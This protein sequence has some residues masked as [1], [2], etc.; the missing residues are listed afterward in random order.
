[1]HNLVSDVIARIL[2]TRTASC[3]SQNVLK[4]AHFSLHAPC[5]Q[6]ACS[7]HCC[8]PR[9][10]GAAPNLN[11]GTPTVTHLPLLLALQDA[12]PAVVPADTA[13]MLVS[14]ALVLLMTPGARVLLRRSGPVQEL[15]QYHDDELRRARR[16]RHRVGAPRPT[17]SPS[18]EGNALDRRRPPTPAGR[19]RRRRPRAPFRTSLF[20]AYQG[21]FAIIT[22]ALISGAIVERMRF[23]PYLAFIALWTLF[24]YAPVAHWVWGGGWLMSR[25]VLDFA[26][27][28]VVHINAGVSALVAALVAGRAQGLRPAGRS[29]RTT[30]RSCCSAPGCSGSAGSASTA[31]ARS[32]PTSSP[33]VAFTNTFLA[34]DGHAGR[35]GAARL[36]PHR[37]RHGGRRRDGD[38]DRPRRHHA[39]RRLHQPDERAAARRPRRVPELLRHRR[40]LAHAARRLARRLRRPRHRR[41]HRRAAHRRVRL[42]GVE[43]GGQ[44]RPAGRQPRRSSPP[45]RSASSRS[46]VYA[47]VGTFVILKLHGSGHRARAPCRAPRDWA[48]TL[49]STAKRPTPTARARSWS[50]PMRSP[51]TRPPAPSPRNRRPADGRRTSAMKLIVAIIRPDRLNEVLEA[52]YRAEVTRSHRLP[53]PRSRRRD[54]PGRDLPR[55]DREDGAAG[56][57]AARDRRVG[58]VR[59]RHRQ[60]DP[61]LGPHRRGGR[62]QGLRA[63]RRQVHRIRTGERDEQAVTPTAHGR[64]VAARPGR[65][66][67]G[68]EGH[69]HACPSS[70]VR[71]GASPS[72][73]PGRL[74]GYTHCR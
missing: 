70:L 19:R 43:P 73:A 62:R 18:R 45:R 17:A 5:A 24:V 26:G 23:G 30:C 13:W 25:G 40:A 66:A 46:I 48:W 36:L 64:G 4:S 33:R 15:A 61:R 12:A 67:A 53:R 72:D 58:A 11:P 38:R 69:A 52:L 63:R 22:A 49:P 54:R 74:A 42:E 55:H 57:G 2:P 56:K 6:G 68:H 71:S 9:H 28:T 8:Q 32:R 21:T 20:M 51:W 34:P 3:V 27:G 29:C 59:R 39:G 47:A 14:T 65:S 31:G 10:W 1:M 60:G 35:L 41:H 44:R 37:P 16:R 50:C 7:V